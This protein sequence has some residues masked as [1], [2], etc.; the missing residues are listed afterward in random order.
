MTAASVVVA[1]LAFTP[2]SVVP[3]VA[4]TL[5]VGLTY[6]ILGVIV[7]IVLGRLGGVYVMLFSPMVD[8]LMFQNPLATEAPE[9]TRLLP[10]HYAT[11]ALFDA[12]FTSNIDPW[13]FGG[14]VAYATV[15]LAIGVLVFY[16]ATDVD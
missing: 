8:V 11:T 6:G 3:F 1:V 2:E 9:W 5:L 4:A 10:S 16:R 15:L 14:A 13:D 7:G 12:A